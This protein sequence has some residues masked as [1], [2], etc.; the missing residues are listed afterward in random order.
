MTHD[1]ER[2][3]GWGCVTILFASA[4][5]AGIS[6]SLS[7]LVAGGLAIWLFYLV[8]QRLSG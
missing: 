6:G 1:M 3:F 4:I 2:D 7:P 5:A 8:C